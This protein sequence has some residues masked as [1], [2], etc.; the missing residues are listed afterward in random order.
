MDSASHV[1]GTVLQDDMGNTVTING[2]TVQRPVAFSPD[3]RAQ[4][5][6]FDAP[7]YANAVS[8]WEA[9]SQTGAAAPYF[10]GTFDGASLPLSDLLAKGVIFKQLFEY[11]ARKFCRSG[12][13]GRP[14][15]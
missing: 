8:A 12:Y 13:L 11:A 1:N 10:A 4:R 6:T 14:A 9:L 3:F 2:Q 5:G 7:L 15:V